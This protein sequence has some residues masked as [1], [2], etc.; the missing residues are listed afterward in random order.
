M[1]NVIKFEVQG[2]HLPFIS[3]MHD[4]A[5]LR[6]CL[7]NSD[8]DFSDLALKR[9]QN[10]WLWI[11]LR[12]H[13]FCKLPQLNFTDFIYCSGAPLPH[14]RCSCSLLTFHCSYESFLDGWYCCW[15]QENHNSAARKC[16]KYADRL[17]F[18]TGMDVQHKPALVPPN[19]P[20]FSHSVSTQFLHCS[21]LC[22]N[23]V[24]LLCFIV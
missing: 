9:K 22:L 13:L 5:V 11:Y 10:I 20:P 2:S 8:S 18:V 21:L 14:P 3:R 4:D 17:I 6:V 19:Q 15:G 16:I 23:D 1:W 24:L 7:S 12:R